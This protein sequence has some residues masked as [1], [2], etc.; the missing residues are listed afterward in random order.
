MGILVEA[1]LPGT[2]IAYPGAYLGERSHRTRVSL[3][4]PRRQAGSACD[5]ALFP[6]LTKPWLGRQS[7]RTLH[8]SRDPLEDSSTM[9]LSSSSPMS[10]SGTSRMPTGPLEVRPHCCMVG[11]RNPISLLQCNTY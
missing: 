10:P 3:Q 8:H 4:R 6:E 11:R 9:T 2:S 7:G 1:P 5:Q